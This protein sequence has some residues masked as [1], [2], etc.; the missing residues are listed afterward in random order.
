MRTTP[1]RDHENLDVGGS[2]TREAGGLSEGAGLDFGEFVAGL[3][4]EAGGKGVV[5]GGWNRKFFGR[6]ELAHFI[7]L[8]L[9]VACIFEDEFGLRGDVVVVGRCEVGE[10]LGEACK[11]PVGAAEELR[12]G[13]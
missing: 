8:T 11:V 6:S 12:E 7:L 9:D 3:S 2:D 5:E 10:L 13:G 4:A 1:E